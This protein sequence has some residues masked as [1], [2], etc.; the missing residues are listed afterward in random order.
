MQAIN[1]SEQVKKKIE[2]FTEQ[3]K[4]TYAQK[5]VSII[6]YGS[7]A[8]GEYVEKR[9]NINFLVI[10]ENNESAELKKAG[11]LI[12][13]F[14]AF[15]PLFLSQDYIERSADVFPIEFLDLKEN[16]VLLYGKDI[17]KN[18]AIDEKNLRFQ[19]EHELKAKLIGLRQH[20]LVSNA[21]GAYLYPVLL[22][23]FTSV[24]HIARNILRLMGKAVPYKKEEILTELSKSLAIDMN[25]WG[26]LL[27]AKNKKIR[28]AENE[29]EN[30]YLRF[31]NE[32]EK[33]VEA[34]DKL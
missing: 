2:L 14:P 31:I 19:C 18:I 26:V 29:K 13:K 8:S 11:R 6:I 20:Y 12:N 30:L 27:S 4:S 33:I 34:V 15:E 16:Y 9:S 7:A 22:K 24:L 17:L 23:A 21:R 32:I 28:V 1:V 25:V 3:L 5:L 10:L